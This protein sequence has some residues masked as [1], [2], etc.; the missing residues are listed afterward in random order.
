MD[1]KTFKK[2][3]LKEDVEE[4]PNNRKGKI[5]L[6][7]VRVLVYNHIHFLEDCLKSILNQK[8]NF[9]YEILI[10]EDASNDGSREK[11]IE[12]AQKYPDKIRLLL[13]SRKNNIPIKGRPSGLFNSVYSNFSIE[14]KYIALCEADDYWTDDHSLQHRVNFLENNKDHVLCFH[15]AVEFEGDKMVTYNSFI[16]TSSPISLSQTELLKV[17]IPTASLMFRHK[18]IE[19]FDE[20]MKEILCGDFILKGKLSLHGKG[21]YLPHIAPSVRRIHQDGCHSSLSRLQ[22]T[23]HSIEA[24]NYLLKKFK[25]IS[26]IEKSLQNIISKLYMSIF[27]LDLKHRN[28]SVEY[29]QGSLKSQGSAWNWMAFIATIILDKLK[30][31][32]DAESIKKLHGI[33]T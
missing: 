17:T 12:F 20:E 25:R 4:Y 6:V 31:K 13:N 29:L 9:D 26:W 24:R 7:T 3:Y 28:F 27:L 19:L 22:Q 14:S 5:P 32:K 10:A 21:R 33:T 1:F 11:C 16:S 30:I 23:I 2:K 18:L 8:V 15:R